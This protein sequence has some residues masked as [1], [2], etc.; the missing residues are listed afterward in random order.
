MTTDCLSDIT[1]ALQ[2]RRLELVTEDLA[3]YLLLAQS[4]TIERIGS[5]YPQVVKEIVHEGIAV[6]LHLLS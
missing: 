5:T 3:L 4:F 2:D 6:R 1:E